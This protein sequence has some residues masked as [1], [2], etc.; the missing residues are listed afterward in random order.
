MKKTFLTATKD[1]GESPIPYLKTENLELRQKE[2]EY[3]TLQTRLLDLQHSLKVLQEYKARDEVE[4]QEAERKETRLMNDTQAEIRAL[5]GNLAECEADLKN[6]S[7]ESESYKNILATK[8][9]EIND[10]KR[11]LS[12][13]LEEIGK[14][15]STQRMSESE[16]NS[17][18][19]AWDAAKNEV[20]RLSAINERIKVSNSD[21]IE[22]ISSQKGEIEKVAKATE[23]IEEQ[24]KAI[25]EEIEK[26]DNL[27]K[28]SKEARLA[29]E[30]EVE[31]I[32]A[33]SKK[34]R[35][36]NVEI[37]SRIA[38][39]ESQI[40]KTDQAIS[41]V[42]P[43]L[44]RIDKENW[45][46]KYEQSYVENKAIEVKQRVKELEYEKN[47]LEHIEANTAKDRELEESLLAKEK[48]RREELDEQRKEL[49]RALFDKDIEIENIKRDLERA[50][51]K[52]RT[53]IDDHKHAVDELTAVK[54]HVNVLEAHH[55]EVMLCMLSWSK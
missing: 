23:E 16:Y 4:Y 32:I 15:K 27:L 20:D 8:N 28:A 48:L 54:G 37:S 53:V 31:L 39:L 22:K 30:R 11:R 19:Q 40:S 43:Q 3:N 55:E 2:K 12:D 7:T 36:K 33:E 35:E 21:D 47:T 6:L 9:S 29:N 10:L 52:Y 24:G 18:L 44:E 1:S 42:S 49:E 26:L 25:E 46:A 34:R 38:A 50:S 5:R 17:I 45:D 41:N 14:T 51:N 13:A